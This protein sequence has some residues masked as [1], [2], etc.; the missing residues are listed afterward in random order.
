MNANCFQ[1]HQIRQNNLPIYES[2]TRAYILGNTKIQ[3]KHAIAQLPLTKKHVQ[4]RVKWARKYVRN[5]DQFW[6]CVI[7]SNKTGL[8]ATERTGHGAIC[9]NYKTMYSTH[10]KYSVEKIV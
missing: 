2:R 4:D 1:T 9:K 8:L 3:Y 5:K 7:F 10:P 6:N